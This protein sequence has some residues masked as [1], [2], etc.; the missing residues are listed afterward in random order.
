MTMPTDIGAIDLMISFPKANAS[1]TYDYLRETTRGDDE[2]TK[3]FPAGYMFKDVPNKLDEGD[4]GVNVAV[5]EMDKWGVDIGMTGAGTDTSIRAQKDHPGRFITSLEID[6]NDITGAVRKIRQYKDEHDI[7]AITT[8]PAGCNPQVPVDDRRYYPIYQTCIDLDIPIISN[9][10]IAGP[11][12]P[13]KCQDVMLF[14]QVCYDFPELRIVMR[15]GAEPWE[16]LAVK[17][18]LKWPNLYYMPSAFAPKH[19]PEAIIEYA[20]TR[21]A[22]KIMYAGYYPMGLTLERIFTEMPN[23][24][25]RDHVWPKFLRDNAIRVFKLD[26][27]P[28]S[29]SASES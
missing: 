18:M 22:D 17:L 1:K 15:H 3:E 13:S 7:K 23:V 20:N 9:A 4:D 27:R 10:G 29:S 2:S 8:F 24:P 14:D 21:G 12:F 16:E 5:A 19:Y 6:P 26:A 28:Y 25:F 11:R